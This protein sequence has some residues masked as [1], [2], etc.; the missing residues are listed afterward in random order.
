MKTNAGA[1]VVWPMSVVTRG[2][3]A[4]PVEQ[5][6]VRGTESKGRLGR[7]RRNV[8]PGLKIALAVIIALV[9]AVSAR[10][11]VWPDQGMPAKVSAIVALDAPGPTAT[12]ALRLAAEQ[13]APYLLISLGAPGTPGSCPRPVHQV[14]LICFHPT[15]GTTQ[16]EAEFTGRLARKYH[17]SSI[18]VVTIAPQDPRARLR[19][20]R[21]FAGP[22]Y[23]VTAPLNP[24]QT[25]WPYQIA[26]EWGALAK[27]LTI[28]RA[29]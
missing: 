15:P 13:R 23:V 27:A 9:L 5:S 4:V 10:L 3:P 2:T 1:C 29:C 11:F 21:C 28:Q 6:P 26:Y 14:T 18:T 17:W 7:K 8:R 20:E 16:G 19:M 25:T 22:V 12:V 24:D